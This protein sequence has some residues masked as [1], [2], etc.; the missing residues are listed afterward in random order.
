LHGSDRADPAHTL[1]RTNPSNAA[2]RPD[3]TY[4]PY[5][6]PARFF[7]EEQCVA[8]LVAY[9][10]LLEP[11]EMLTR[12]RVDGLVIEVSNGSSLV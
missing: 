6:T 2:Y 1:D 7:R 9:P 5:R 4:R 12:V 11:S 8:V 3:L 10:A